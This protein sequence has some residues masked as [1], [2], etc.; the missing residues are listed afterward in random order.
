ML[1]VSVILTA[2]VLNGAPVN[3]STMKDNVKLKITK[4][5]KAV[6]DGYKNTEEDFKQT[7]LNKEEKTDKK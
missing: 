1:T 3:D 5:E 4:T 6:V 7:I 2:V